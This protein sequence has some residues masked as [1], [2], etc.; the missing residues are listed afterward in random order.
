MAAQRSQWS[1]RVLNFVNKFDGNMDTCKLTQHAK[2][3][4]FLSK[5]SGNFEMES[6]KNNKVWIFSC[7]FDLL[8]RIMDY[9]KNFY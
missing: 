2:L 9:E 6:D 5:S 7:V 1:E 3:G 4:R 8:L